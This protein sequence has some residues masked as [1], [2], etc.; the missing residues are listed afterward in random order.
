MGWF[1]D[2]AHATSVLTTGLTEDT[3]RLN[4]VSANSIQPILTGFANI[5]AGF[6]IAC[7]FCWQMACICLIVV[8]F[9]LI[10]QFYTVRITNGVMTSSREKMKEANLLLGDAIM[11]YKTVQSFG[12]E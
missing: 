8:P 11:N 3:T 4:D 9:N 5:L 1:D 6:V 7:I 12:R 2:R 10:S